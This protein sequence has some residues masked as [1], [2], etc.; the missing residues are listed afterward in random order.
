MEKLVGK[1]I[2]SCTEGISR[3]KTS[4]Y[5]ISA[6]LLAAAT[7]GCSAE[8]EEAGGAG[9]EPAADSEGRLSQAKGELG[10]LLRPADPGAG[11]APSSLSAPSSGV[12]GCAPLCPGGCVPVQLA[13]VAGL[14]TSL[15]L[16]GDYVFFGGAINHEANYSFLG[17]VPK[18]GGPKTMFDERL[19]FTPRLMSNGSSAYVIISSPPPNSPLVKF[20]R[21]GVDGTVTPLQDYS[22][23]TYMVTMDADNFYWWKSSTNRVMATPISGAPGF[24]VTSTVFPDNSMAERSLKA[25]DHKIYIVADDVQNGTSTLWS[26]PKTGPSKPKALIKTPGSIVSLDVTDPTHVYYADRNGGLFKAP[27]SGGPVVELAQNA[28]EM[29]IAVDAER[30]YWFDGPNLTATCKDGSGS[31]VLAAV[32]PPDTDRPAI[33][34]VDSSAVYWRSYSQIFKIAK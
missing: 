26:S 22:M 31:Q 1:F 18:A 2:S 13:R 32:S 6:F 15:I 25:D 7:A 24:Q 17:T 34:S 4:Y 28:A 30:Y 20:N 19:W 8:V 33:M 5:A 29:S 12:V 3:R 14:E 11:F 23:D 27:K 16:L 21:L 10:G 9:A